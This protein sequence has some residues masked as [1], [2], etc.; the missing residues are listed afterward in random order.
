[1]FGPETHTVGS[2][3]SVDPYISRTGAYW[4]RRYDGAGTRCA[5]VVLPL[6]AVELE[7]VA[8]MAVTLVL[9]E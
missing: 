7:E 9:L 8:L 6:R 4:G 5:L 3:I 1:M 2:S